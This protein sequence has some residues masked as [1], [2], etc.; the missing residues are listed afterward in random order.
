MG[1]RI[2]EKKIFHIIE[3]AFESNRKKIKQTTSAKMK[4][5]VPNAAFFSVCSS[6][7]FEKKKR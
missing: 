3:C 7:F 6:H 1:V 4:K 2:A 5:K